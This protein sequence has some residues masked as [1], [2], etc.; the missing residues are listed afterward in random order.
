MLLAMPLMVV[1]QSR[2]YS[3]NSTYSSDVVL[4]FDG[5]RIYKGSSTYSSDVL[6]TVDGQV[7]ILVLVMFL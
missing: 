6:Y 3:G 5:K 2:V 7:P 4:T 1:A